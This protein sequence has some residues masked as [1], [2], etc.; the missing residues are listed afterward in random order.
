[1]YRGKTQRK[2]VKQYNSI[3]NKKQLPVSSSLCN[4]SS[5]LL[6]TW[7]WD[8]LTAAAMPL[9]TPRCTASSMSTAKA[10]AP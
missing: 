3:R 6:C 2:T 9:D 8:D 7:Y 4:F 1:V 5:F 10:A